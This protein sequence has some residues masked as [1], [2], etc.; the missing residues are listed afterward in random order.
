VQDPEREAVS[1]GC[2]AGGRSAGG[3]VATLEVDGG[4]VEVRAGR[5]RLGRGGRWVDAPQALVGNVGQEEGVA[6]PEGP[7]QKRCA[8]RPLTR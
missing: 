8:E 4:M 2:G 7:Y 1:R 3:L 6:V 5:H